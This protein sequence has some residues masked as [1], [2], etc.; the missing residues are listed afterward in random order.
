[1]PPGRWR[2]G[3]IALDQLPEHMANAAAQSPDDINH[4]FPDRDLLFIYADDDTASAEQLAAWFPQG[5]ESRLPTYKEDV[6]IRTYRV[7]A[8]G[9]G[10]GGWLI[11]NGGI[12]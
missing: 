3:D 10:L 11:E 5:R 7:P 1:M 8:L 12:K 4:L 6:F 9:N 2:N